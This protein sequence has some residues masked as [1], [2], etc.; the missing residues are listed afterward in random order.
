MR[1]GLRRSVQLRYSTM[2]HTAKDH[3]TVPATN[4]CIAARYSPRSMGSSE[5]FL[6]LAV[7]WADVRV[8]LSKWFGRMEFM[9]RVSFGEAT[10]AAESGSQLYLKQFHPVCL[11]R[12]HASGNPHMGLVLCSFAGNTATLYSRPIPAEWF[13]TGVNKGMERE[14]GL[15]LLFFGDAYHAGRCAGS[16]EQPHGRAPAEITLSTRTCGKVRKQ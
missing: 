6:M 13:W 9:P 16:D 12:P 4:R 11:D 15:P 2:A 7:V 5:A 8:A 10:G 3:S 1:S 14:R